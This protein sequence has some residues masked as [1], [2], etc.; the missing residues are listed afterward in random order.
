MGVGGVER[1]EQR[2]DG[3]RGPG[4]PYC[5]LLVEGDL[6]L[7]QLRRHLQRL[8]DLGVGGYPSPAEER[9]LL[10]RAAEAVRKRL[11]RFNRGVPAGLTVELSPDLA[12]LLAE[13]PM[14]E[15]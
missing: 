1:S 5:G 8:S 6:S 2:L 9:R 15:A 13:G 11:G 10:R 4:L 14:G 7:S 12:A 3:V